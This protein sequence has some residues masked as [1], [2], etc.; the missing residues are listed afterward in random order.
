LASRFAEIADIAAEAART[1]LGAAVIGPFGVAI[2][3]GSNVGAVR[4]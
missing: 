2:L 3:G 4:A 1:A